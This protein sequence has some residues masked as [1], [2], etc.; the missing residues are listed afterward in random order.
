MKGVFKKLLI[1]KKGN[2]DSGSA[3]KGVIYFS[4]GFWLLLK[5]GV[6]STVAVT[7]ILFSSPILLAAIFIF[8]IAFIM[9]GK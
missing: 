4:A 9:R 3:I 7:G 1:N 2:G 8:I 6:I 5:M